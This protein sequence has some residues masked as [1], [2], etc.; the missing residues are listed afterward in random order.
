M[1]EIIS[2]NF[3]KVKPI[4]DDLQIYEPDYSIVSRDSGF[5]RFAH[6][7]EQWLKLEKDLNHKIRDAVK[8]I[9]CCKYAFGVENYI[10]DH[11]Q[12]KVSTC[13][14]QGGFFDRIVPRLTKINISKKGFAEIFFQ[15]LG[16]KERK[17]EYLDLKN[18][19]D[20]ILKEHYSGLFVG[21]WNDKK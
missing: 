21:V 13:I 16:P 7:S 1:T 11:L 8:I 2:K 20:R 6:A 17:N 19:Y 5:L 10:L 4:P 3:K 9:G 14:V 15:L 12:F 18:E